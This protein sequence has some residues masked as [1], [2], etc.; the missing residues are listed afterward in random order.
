MI[1]WIT[2]RSSSGKT[3][4]AKRL[5]RQ[6]QDLGGQIV[7]LDGDEVRDQFSNQEYE[8]KDREK[9]I[10]TIANFASILEKQG[11]IVIIALISP[12]KDWRMKAR[13]LFEK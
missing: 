4:Y 12:K 9:H 11:F 13:K 8:D 2:G 5:K 7:L 10:M 3:V 1:Y 6:L